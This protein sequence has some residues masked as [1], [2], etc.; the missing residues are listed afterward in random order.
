MYQSLIHLIS[1]SFFP[2]GTPFLSAYQTA[3]HSSLFVVQV[4]ISS[5]FIS[6]LSFFSLSS[7]HILL[8]SIQSVL[9]LHSFTLLPFF[10]SFL[11]SIHVFFHSS[12][13]TPSF[14]LNTLFHS[15]IW[16]VDF[17]L[18][19]YSC[20]HSVP[21]HSFIY[22]SSHSI[23][24]SSFIPSISIGSHFPDCSRFSLLFLSSCL[25]ACLFSL[26]QSI[27]LQ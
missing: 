2:L 22:L 5:L 26:R 8:D 20:M 11:P 7:L 23:H 18:R 15:L 13:S 17:S 1:C 25:C 6:S 12:I 19:Y 10:P 21:S 3:V 9:T 24:F 16:R 14:S 4:Q 27:E